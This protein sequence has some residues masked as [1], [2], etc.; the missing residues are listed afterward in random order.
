MTINVLGETYKIIIT[1]VCN[2]EILQKNK[3]SGY[4]SELSK[5][6]IVA[7]MTEEEFF[8][9]MTDSDREK[10]K[11]ETL[12]HE[13]IHAFLTESGLGNNSSIPSYGWAK[14]EEM[15]D[16]IAIQS[17]KIIEAFEKAG[18]L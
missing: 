12:R 4:C 9:D 18:A 2:N 14:N 17:P 16:W 15:I 1:K 6:V 11:K 7:D 10:Y 8:P 3:W 13:I 5:Q